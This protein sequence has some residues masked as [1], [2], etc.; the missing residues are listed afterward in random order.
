MFDSGVSQS[1]SK[2]VK[3]LRSLRGVFVAIAVVLIIVLG[4][5]A[6][7][8]VWP[9]LVVVESSSMQHSDTHSYI[10]VIDTGDLVIVKT[11]GGGLAVRPYLDSISSGYKTYSEYGDVVIYHPLGN[12]YVTP[13]I[14]RAICSVEYNGTGGGYDVPALKNVPADM[15][16]V[17][18][19]PKVWYNIQGTLV[20]KGIGYNSVQVS[21]DF[22]VIKSH[23]GSSP[24]GGLIT[25]GDNNQ[26][27]VDQMTSIC[28]QPVKG[29]WIE[30]MARG[31][32]PWFGLLKLWISGPTP[33]SVPQNSVADLWI[34][35]ALIIGV[36]IALDA[37]ALVMERRGYDFWAHVRAKLGMKPKAKKE[38]EGD[39]EPAKDKPSE[40]KSSGGAQKQ[41]Q[42]G[43]GKPEQDKDKKA[44]GGK[45]G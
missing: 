41:G 8:G 28:P 15:W 35:I 11:L 45:K 32:L 44:K 38:E 1:G 42:G 34:C 19:G 18:G 7:S 10:G 27:V 24:Q 3:V 6:Y 2:A 17:S 33:A 12:T 25:L 14:H 29:E 4:L 13:I 26:G 37:A 31:E 5:W 43:K 30:G 40:K 36:P 20:L 22:A 9:P 16:S 21:I 23:S 39:A